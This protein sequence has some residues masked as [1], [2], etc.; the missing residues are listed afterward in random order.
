MAT[1]SGWD[2]ARIVPRP[3]AA[4]VTSAFALVTSASALAGTVTSCLDDQ[5]P[6]TL[7]SVITAAAEGETINFAGG[8]NCST[9]SSMAGEIYIHQDSLTIDGATLING[10]ASRMTVDASNLA[11][12]F[13]LCRVFNHQGAGTLTLKNL[14]A[15]HGAA[16]N[17]Q[18]LLTS[19][20]GGCILSYGSVTLEQVEVSHCVSYS[21]LSSFKYENGAPVGGGIAARNDV[22]LT[23][24]SVTYSTTD[25]FYGA[26]GGGIYANNVSLTNSL[27][28][29]DTVTC[30]GN[31]KCYG[32]GVFAKGNL[33]ITSSGVYYNTA[34]AADEAAGGGV[35]V[36]GDLNIDGALSSMRN[37]SV[38]SKNKRARGGAAFVQGSFSS[39]AE[40]TWV[41]YNSVASQGG[42]TSGGGLY[43]GGI[44]TLPS[45]QVTGNTAGSS[46]GSARGGGARVLGGSVLQYSTMSNNAA[47]DFG[48]GGALDVVGSTTIRHSTISGNSAG[49]A[50]GGVYATSVAPA[51][52]SLTLENSTISGNTADNRVG[53]LYTNFGHV[54]FFNS[55]IAFNSAVS[56]GLSQAPGVDLIGPSTVLLQ[57]TLIS[58]NSVG[59]VD[60]DLSTTGNVTFSAASSANLVRA[61]AVANLP[62]GS[63][64]FGACPLLAPLR[65]N[66][67]LT[68][69]HAPQSHS[70]VIDHGG[71]TTF[72][73]PSGFDQRGT[74][75]NN[76][77][78]G[79]YP[80]I[81]GPLNGSPVADIGAYE[82]NQ[83]E[84]VFDTNFEGCNS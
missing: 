62:P 19:P 64:I 80:R 66:G 11:R 8:L 81:L 46:G 49:V 16:A 43:V 59:T 63:T 73:S 39:S 32:G 82:V 9:V 72:A 68:W 10:V 52:L 60:N 45:G 28:S 75:A 44:L 21:H 26:R 76:Q 50:F 22:K 36:G 40:N 1:V 34:N 12:P 25:G 41:K 5:S 57:N 4:C 77:S 61:T 13:G 53:G 30:S 18:L 74:S 67:G 65:L 70:P 6:G 79:V 71:P 38:L 37:N 33:D 69:T 7:R 35:H 2:F 55:T 47:N 23:N 17:Y 42:D 78:A 54:A 58:N 56:T 27:I 29:H 48:F 15:T 24:S 3:I 14:I 51:A 83:S 20:Y 31:G 84:V